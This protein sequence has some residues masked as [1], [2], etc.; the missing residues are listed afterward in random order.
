MA[1]TLGN[2]TAFS[3]ANAFV[4]D[5]NGAER[6]RLGGTNYGLLL[7]TTS[8]PTGG[9]D[10]AGKV[11]MVASDRKQMM[12]RNTAATAG[13]VETMGMDSDSRFYVLSNNS[14]G[15]Y[16]TWTGTSWTST[17][18]ER[19]KTNLMPI[20]NALSKVSTARTMIGRFNHDEPL[21][22]RSFFIAQDFQNIL[23]EAVY[24]KSGELGLS[25]TSTI[26]LIIASIKELKI[27]LDSVSNNQLSIAK[28]DIENIE[29][30]LQTLGA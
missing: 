18:D 21:K 11:T 14:T 4:Y 27:K 7:N 1:V 10:G 24:D 3:D 12:F 29:L 8:V 30:D 9:E 28:S 15:L 13:R 2:N 6:A 19:E 22:R 20:T 5:V 23:P 17:S 25:Y 16:L 26:P